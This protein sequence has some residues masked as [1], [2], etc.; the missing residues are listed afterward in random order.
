MLIAITAKFV[1]Y[2]KANHLHR[3]SQQL[4]FIPMNSIGYAS[5][6]TSHST[7]PLQMHSQQTLPLEMQSKSFLDSAPIFLIHL[8]PACGWYQFSLSAHLHRHYLG[9]RSTLTVLT[10][11]STAPGAHVIAPCHVRPARLWSWGCILSTS[12]YDTMHPFAS[13]CS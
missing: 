1:K 12:D 9:T 2:Q 10:V 7:L 5:L 8:S 3:A 6:A 13:F 4:W 11:R